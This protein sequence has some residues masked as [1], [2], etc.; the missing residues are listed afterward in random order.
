M[1]DQVSDCAADKDCASLNED[2]PEIY[3]IPEAFIAPNDF[4]K[5]WI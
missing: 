1:G 3:K 2:G 5:P 4:G